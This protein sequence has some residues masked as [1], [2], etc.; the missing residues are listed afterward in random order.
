MAYHL[1]ALKERRSSTAATAA[2]ASRRSARAGDLD[3]PAV[4]I[5]A[6]V[7]LRPLFGP[8]GLGLPAPPTPTPTP[9]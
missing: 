1:E 5:I 2:P 9:R 3:S 7:A 6:A 8:W 4:I